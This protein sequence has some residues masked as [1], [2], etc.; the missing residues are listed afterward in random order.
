MGITTHIAKEIRDGVDNKKAE[1]LNVA[2]AV[3]GVVGNN[4]KNGLNRFF[5]REIDQQ[6]FDA[7]LMVNEQGAC[8]SGAINDGMVLSVQKLAQLSGVKESFSGQVNMVFLITR[9]FFIPHPY[10][11]GRSVLWFWWESAAGKICSL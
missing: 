2:D 5:R 6:D 1:L 10:L 4:E 9:R 7:I 8:I 3:S 11:W